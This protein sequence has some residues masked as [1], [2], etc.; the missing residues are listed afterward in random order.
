VVTEHSIEGIDTIKS[1]VSYTLPA[2]VEN[3][4]LLG[5]ANINGTGNSLNNLIIGNTGNNMLSGGGGQDTLQG[6]WGNDTYL[7]C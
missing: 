4:V 2:Q 1:S 3:L 5:T 7:D 6:G